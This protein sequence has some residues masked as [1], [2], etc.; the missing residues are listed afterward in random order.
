MLSRWWRVEGGVNILYSLSPQLYR[1]RLT[2]CKIEV[3][4]RELEAKREE[5]ADATG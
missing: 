1:R 3:I 5:G 2:K 4:E